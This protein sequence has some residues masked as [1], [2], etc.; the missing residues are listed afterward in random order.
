M[1]DFQNGGQL[2]SQNSKYGIQ[3][4]EMQYESG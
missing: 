4:D 2:K 1:A 3:H